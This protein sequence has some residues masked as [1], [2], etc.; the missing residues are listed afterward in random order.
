M[1]CALQTLDNGTWGCY[2]TLWT[3]C[4]MRSFQLFAYFTSYTTRTLAT[5]LNNFHASITCPD[6]L[7]LKNT[8]KKSY[9]CTSVQFNELRTVKETMLKQFPI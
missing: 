2:S 5:L 7:S 3:L 1:K 4:G 6:L 8:N 9:P